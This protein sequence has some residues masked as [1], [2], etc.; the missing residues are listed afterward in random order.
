MGDG[1]EKLRQ[2]R[3]CSKCFN[4]SSGV[5]D[6]FKYLVRSCRESTVEIEKCAPVLKI[7]AKGILIR[8]FFDYTLIFDHTLKQIIQVE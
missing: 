3:Q 4:G 8:M 5:A 7:I 1:H 2:Y 6:H